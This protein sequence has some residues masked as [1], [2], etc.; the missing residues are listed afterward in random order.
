[1]AATEPGPPAASGRGDEPLTADL[2]PTG[3]RVPTR[4][5]RVAVVVLVALLL[6]SAVVGFLVLRQPRLTP[7]P[8]PSVS[9][10]S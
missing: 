8:V 7:L 9:S 10:I 1:M 3:R 6:V 5:L 2:A 4:A